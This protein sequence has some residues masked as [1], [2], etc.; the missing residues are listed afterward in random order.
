MRKRKI[1]RQRERRTQIA[2]AYVAAQDDAWQ[3]EVNANT[4]EI[5]KERERERE[6]ERKKK[7]QLC[8]RSPKWSERKSEVNLPAYFRYN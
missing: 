5:E 6:R 4:E 1:E 8:G 2:Q 3:E 7:N